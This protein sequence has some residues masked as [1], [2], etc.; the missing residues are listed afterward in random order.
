MYDKKYDF[1]LTYTTDV[2]P[3]MSE[4]IIELEKYEDKLADLL[5][6]ETKA[7]LQFIF[8]ELNVR[9]QRTDSVAQRSLTLNKIS[10][11]AEDEKTILKFGAIALE[12]NKFRIFKFLSISLIV[13][14][15]SGIIYV[16]LRSSLRNKNNDFS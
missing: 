4:V 7:E 10:K 6:S 5:L 3:E 15:L 9:M 2:R 14:A 12:E 8:K 13:G 1:A 16:L 11:F